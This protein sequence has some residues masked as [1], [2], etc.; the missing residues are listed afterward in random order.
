MS[1]LRSGSKALAYRLHS[2][3]SWSSHIMLGTYP[4]GEPSVHFYNAMFI[5]NFLSV[6]DGN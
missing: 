2:G 3:P 1:S 5:P 4:L 6:S